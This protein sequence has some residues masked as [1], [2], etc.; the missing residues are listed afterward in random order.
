[1]TWDE[2]G[3]VFFFLVLFNLMLQQQS[4]KNETYSENKLKA[5]LDE[6]KS[7]TI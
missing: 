4:E 2:R 7:L 3:F 1:M 6:L 5:K